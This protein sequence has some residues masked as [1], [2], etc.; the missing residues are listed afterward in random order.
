MKRQ[1]AINALEKTL[2]KWNGLGEHCKFEIINDF[3]KQLIIEKHNIKHPILSKFYYTPL[4][5]ELLIKTGC[6]L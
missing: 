3:R 1:Q 4:E 2:D 6:E 5:Y